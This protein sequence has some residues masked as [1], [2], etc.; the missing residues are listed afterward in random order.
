MHTTWIGTAKK[1]DLTLL[2]YDQIVLDRMGF[3]L[4][5]YTAHSP[6]NG[7]YGVQ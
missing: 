4:T 2:I 7:V 5:T 1:Q 6:L 3:L